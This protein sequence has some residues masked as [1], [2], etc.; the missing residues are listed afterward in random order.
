[1]P[2]T[3]E[4]IIMHIFFVTDLMRQNNDQLSFRVIAETDGKFASVL[5][6]CIR[7]IYSFFMNTNLVKLVKTLK[8]GDFIFTRSVFGD[9]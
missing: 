6:A 7:V 8:A 2:S 9:R 1:M 4:V 3:T 5:N